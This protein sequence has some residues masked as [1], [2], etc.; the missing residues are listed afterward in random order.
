MTDRTRSS[1]LI[2]CT[3]SL[4]GIFNHNQIVLF[5]DFHNRVHIGSLPVKMNGDNR[6]SI[7]GD[8]R[9]DLRRINVVSNRIY[10]H[11]NGFS[12][13]AGNTASGIEK[14]I[15]GCDDFISD[16][17]T[18][19][20]ERYQQRICLWRYASGVFAIAIISHSGFAFLNLRP[21]DEILRFK[22]CCHG[23]VDII[24]YWIILRF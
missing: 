20:H 22:H 17:D 6:L 16:A 9:F 1:T 7:R 15:I 13:G 14:W 8:L 18:L 23:F 5:S 24:L 21:I 2:F 10:I 3:D 11:E 4:G 12:A 19:H